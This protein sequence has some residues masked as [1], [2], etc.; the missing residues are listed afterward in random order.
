MQKLSFIVLLF[1]FSIQLLGQDSPH[2]EDFD[3]DC[4]L[5]HTTESWK[6]NENKVKFDHSST[7]F[8]LMGQHKDVNCSSCHTDLKFKNAPTDCENCHADIHE[9]SVGF[10]CAS[11]HTTTSWIVSDILQVHRMGR[12]PL[13]G[14]HQTADCSEC[15]VSNSLLNF[16]PL[17]VECSDCHMDLYQSA[18]KPDHI[19]A[20][21]S[22]D[23]TECHNQA[24]PSWTG[25]GISHGFFPLTGGH[26][27]S[28]CFE[29]HKQDDFKGLSP[30]CYSCHQD[31]YNATTNPS[32]IDLG[33]SQD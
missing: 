4:L 21:Y 31:D 25:A 28:D 26:A 7:K 8:E 18:K 12:F 20:N 30:D 3:L 15:H 9:N 5:C 27:I 10:D 16:Q 33:F 2:G 6:I 29:C 24:Y 11:C 19:S 13:L 17:G 1:F 32:H 22:T 23:C 14:S